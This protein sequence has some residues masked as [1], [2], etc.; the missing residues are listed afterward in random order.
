MHFAFTY[1]DVAQLVARVLWEHDVAGSNPV[2]PTIKAVYPLGYASFI[3]KT[4]F[5]GEVVVND[6]PVDCQSHGKPSPQ[7]GR[8]LSFRPTMTKLNTRDRDADLVIFVFIIKFI[9]SVEKL[10][11]AFSVS[12]Y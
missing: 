5:E 11:L 6:S 12:S 7:A 4:G 3:I 8:T 1:R 10:A 9:A 2:I